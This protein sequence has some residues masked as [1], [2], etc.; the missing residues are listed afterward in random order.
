MSKTKFSV[1][2]IL[3]SDCEPDLTDQM[4]SYYSK[5][6]SNLNS[7]QGSENAWHSFFGKKSEN[8][9]TETHSKSSPGGSSMS[10]MGL[11]K[12]SE[13]KCDSKTED[14]DEAESDQNESE[15]DQDDAS[16]TADTSQN[17]N[18]PLSG[19]KRKRRILFTKHQTYELEKRFKQQ[20]YLSAHERENLAN[21]INLSPTQVKIWFQNH[22][23]KIKRAKQ[24]KELGQHQLN[25]RLQENCA[26]LKN[27]SAYT[28]HGQQN[29]FIDT[30]DKSDVSQNLF[31]SL[32]ANRSML[33]GFDLYEMYSNFLNYNQKVSVPNPIA[34]VHSNSPISSS[35]LIK[36]A[37]LHQMALHRPF[38][39]F[40]NS[41]TSNDDLNEESDCKK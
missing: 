19:K 33:N 31:T 22:R 5:I 13:F 36:L 38:A 21:L 37:S 26:M 17:S 14:E 27:S 30:G 34:N 4:K 32:L 1:E 40:K 9:V 10:S 23:Y 41:M 24:E 2:E 39:E 15:N 25:K 12:S 8:S 6:I 16:D 3:K 11:V 28:R 29:I 20:R 7:L 35:L 18:Q